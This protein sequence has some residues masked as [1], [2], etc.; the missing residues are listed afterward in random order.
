MEFAGSD[1]R[2]KDGSSVQH[3]N[4]RTMDR[5]RCARPHPIRI[6][7][8]PGKLS[9]PASIRNFTRGGLGISVQQAFELGTVLSIQ[10]RVANTGLSCVLSATVIRCQVM[11]D[12]TWLLGCKL[13]RPLNNEETLSLL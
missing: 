8:R 1:P 3:D 12:N 7:I 5:F 9:Y 6:M 2:P 4:R 13:A 11:P 10:L